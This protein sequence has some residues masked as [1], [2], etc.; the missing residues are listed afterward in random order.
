MC[1]G[2]KRADLKNIQAQSTAQNAPQHIPGISRAQA[3][4]IQ[5]SASP[6]ARPPTNPQTRTIQPQAAMPASSTSLR[7]VKNPPIRVR[8][9]VSGRYYE[10][11]GGR[12]V[13]RVD[14]RDASSLL[15][16]GFFRRE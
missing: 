10:F 15:N 12:T 1:C 4:R 11:S 2:Q 9:P 5:S 8:G 7:Y 14:A 3:V 6:P 13:Q 16:T